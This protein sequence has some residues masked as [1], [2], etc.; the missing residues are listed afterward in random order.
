V[1]IPALDCTACGEALV[2]PRIVE[3]AARIFE[4]AGADAWYSRH[5]ADFVPTDSRARTAAG[6]PSSAR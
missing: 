3:H 2:T 1:P 4:A 6:R 5:T